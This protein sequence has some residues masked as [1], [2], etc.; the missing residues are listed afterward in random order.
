MHFEAIV[1]PD[2]IAYCLNT[3]KRDEKSAFLSILIQMRRSLIFEGLYENHEQC[4]YVIFLN[5]CRDF[6]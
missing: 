1:I 5:N 4:G 3:I 2:L 6:R